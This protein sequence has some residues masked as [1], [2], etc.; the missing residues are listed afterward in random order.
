MSCDLAHHDGSYVL[1]ALSPAERQAFERHLDG[2]AECGRSVRELAGLPGLLGRVDADVLVSPPPPEPVPDTLLP[3]LVR[4]VRRSRRRRAWTTAGL[5]A[6]SVATVA[7]VSVA[8]AGVVDDGGSPVADPTPSVPASSA[9]TVLPTGDPTTPS[10]IMV[11]VGHAPVRATVS[12][13]PVDW[14]TRLDLVCTYQPLGGEYGDPQPTTYS[15]VVHTRDGQT[16]QVAT[17]RALPGRTMRLSGAT[18]LTRRE[19]ASVEVR[20]AGGQPVL[21]LRA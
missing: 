7:A 19:I 3:A 15:L 18:S 13:N 10:S 6:A 12:F 20:T 1:G 14:G 17:W 2:C 16:E 5:A 21:Q 4:E 11:P 8:A 9:P